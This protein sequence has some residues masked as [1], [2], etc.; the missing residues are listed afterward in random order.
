[1]YH[2]FSLV[3]ILITNVHILVPVSL[4]KRGYNVVISTSS[5]TVCKLYQKPQVSV[6]LKFV[7]PQNLTN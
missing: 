5:Y 2:N 3:H 4:D 1:M 7:R 6:Q